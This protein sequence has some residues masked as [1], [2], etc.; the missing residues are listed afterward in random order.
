MM[1]KKS[2]GTSKRMPQFAITKIN[3]L[4]LFTEVDLIAVYSENQ[5]KPIYIKTTALK[6]VET[7]GAYNYHWNWNLKC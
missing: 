1:F 7:A 3:W 6:I 2:L 4:M 5:A